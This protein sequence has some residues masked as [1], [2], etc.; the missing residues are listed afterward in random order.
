M[1]HFAQR[2][3]ELFSTSGAN[4]QIVVCCVNICKYFQM[5]SDLFS[6]NI[7]LGTFHTLDF[8]NRVQKGQERQGTLY[9]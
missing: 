5:R 4:L 3:H 8:P 6:L 9:L 1:T 7:G 2:F